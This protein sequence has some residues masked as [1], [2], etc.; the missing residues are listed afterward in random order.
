MNK[1]LE[2]FAENSIRALVT[3]QESDCYGNIA[4]TEIRTDCLLGW[5]VYR[6]CFVFFVCNRTT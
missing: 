3:R 6:E 1:L 2:T 5:I 4:T